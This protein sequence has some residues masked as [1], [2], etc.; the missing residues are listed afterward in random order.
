MKKI[1][2]FIFLFLV[3]F[4]FFSEKN[5]FFLWNGK[6]T[7]IRVHQTR[8][9]VDIV[10]TLEEKRKGLSGRD[11][12]EKNQGM[13]FIFETEKRPSM[14]MKDMKFSLDFLWIDKNYRIVDITENASSASYPQQ[15]YPKVDIRYV[16]E[17]PAGFVK[18][19]NILLNQY[20]SFE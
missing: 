19:N 1:V 5:D 6:F 2:F 8:I 14:W 16:L 20:I 17:V 13:L 9:K 11:F 3:I 12:L 10:K 15:F 7:F 18:E 4:L